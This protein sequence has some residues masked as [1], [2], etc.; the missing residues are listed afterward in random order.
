MSSDSAFAEELLSLLDNPPD[1]SD[2][3]VAFCRSLFIKRNFHRL[4]SYFESRPSAASFPPQVHYWYLVSL[5]KV[6]RHKEAIIH[7]DSLPATVASDP[8]VL[9]VR[10]LCH[11]RD[12]DLQAATSAFM[13]SFAAD[14]LFIE[15]LHKLLSYHLIAERD[16][17][18]LVRS[19]GAVSD[20]LSSYAALS[21]IY[22]RDNVSAFDIASRL[23]RDNP[24]SSRA[25]VVY[26]SYCLV[27]KKRC[28]LFA[29]A[30]RLSN[31][32][33]ES[34]VAMFAAGAHMA[35]MGR[36]EAA[37]SLLC[38]ALR[39]SPFFAPAWI[40]YAITHWNDGDSRTAL[41][42]ILIAARGFPAMELLQIWAG[43]LSGECGEIALAL[44]HYRRCKL[45]GFVLNEMG[46]LLLKQ[47]RLFDAIDVLERAV[48]APDSC[49]VYK[50][51]YAAALRRKGDFEPASQVLERVVGDEPENLAGLLALAFTYHLMLRVD[52]AIVYYNKVLKLTPDHAFAQ[53]MVDDAIQRS[54]ANSVDHYIG[55][56]SSNQF[57]R[58]FAQWKA[59]NGL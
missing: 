42:V 56:E 50:I 14:P 10:G 58:M 20:A 26:I 55:L 41:N 40:A 48:R 15:P 36:S 1:N 44:A 3:A 27:L 30:Q 4:I 9:Y 38:A 59:T 19:G 25:T 11:L 45:N 54:S 13:A 17:E 23:M 51:N 57:D 16:Y 37:R 34:P 43:Y 33:P 8:R 39:G 47:G 5:V 22:A 29:F 7:L 32:S 6:A 46:C 52:D 28:E 18:Q 2:D 31:S 53:G 12:L 35:L 24:S 49:A 21:W